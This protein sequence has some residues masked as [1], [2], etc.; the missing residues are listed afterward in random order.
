MAVSK[1]NRIDFFLFSID[2]VG[3]VHG[4]EVETVAS[5]ACALFRPSTLTCTST[6]C[7]CTVYK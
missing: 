2:C 7:F 6:L 5:A 4:A 1:F 3:S